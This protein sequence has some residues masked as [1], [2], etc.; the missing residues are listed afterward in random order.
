MLSQHN[1]VG[2][3]KSGEKDKLLKKVAVSVACSCGCESVANVRYVQKEEMKLV[4]KK[5]NGRHE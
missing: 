1:T 2:E 4:E 3:A 5:G